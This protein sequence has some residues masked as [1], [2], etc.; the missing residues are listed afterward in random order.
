MVVVESRFLAHEGPAGVEAW[1]EQMASKMRVMTPVREGISVVFRDHVAGAKLQFEDH[2]AAG[3]K[4]VVFPQT[5]Y[6]MRFK[7]ERTAPV[8]GHRRLEL[9]P[10]YPDE[11][12]LL[13]GANPCGARGL[14]LIDKVF[15]EGEYVDPYYKARRE[16]TVIAS[17][18]CETPGNACFCHWVG[19]GPGD[20]RGSDLLLTPVS[21]GYLV[22][23]VTE[24]GKAC[25][26]ETLP[27]ATKEQQEEAAAATSK[28]AAALPQA[29]DIAECR[30]KLHEAFS[31]MDFWSDVAGNCIH[32]GAC[33]YYCPTCYCFNITDE[34]SGLAGERIR[35]WDSCMFPHY[36]QE[37]SGHNPRSMRAHRMRNRVLH[38]FGFYPEL[39]GENSCTGCGRCIRLCPMGVDIREIVL[40][41]MER[42]TEESNA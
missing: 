4:S 30:D 21:G 19:G 15:L 7:A 27:V 29:P 1:L 28:A 41:A 37:A 3:P 14:E 39:Y 40:S 8:G 31:D 16:R 20:T 34:A 33:T 18:S 2:A 26:G 42:A 32:C 9:E 22:D 12:I 10:V 11:D 13:F 36:T 5:E 35:S 23:V 24:K 25:V 17:I 38:K 6:L